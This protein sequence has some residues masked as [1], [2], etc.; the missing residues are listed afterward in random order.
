VRSTL[1][2]TLVLAVTPAHADPADRVDSAAPDDLVNRPLVLGEG[3]L[4][5]R[6]TAEINLQPRFVARPLSF[7][8]DAWWGISPRWTIGLVHSNASLD[9][10]EAGATLCVRESPIS[11]CNRLYRGS[12]L[13]VRF[14]ARAGA[15][16]IAPRVRVLVRD[17][18]P[19][20]PAI[21]LGALVRWSHGRFAIAG[22]PY[23]RLPL[24]NH[25]LGNRAALVVPLWLAVQ[26]ARGWELAVHTGY[27]ADLVVLR[28][29]GHI[30]LGLA[31][32]ARATRELDVRVLAGWSRLLGP[33]HDAQRAALMITA[34]WHRER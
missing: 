12:G 32:T 31:V 25:S 18:D 23:L 9:R 34:G 24:A 33:Q 14:S 22:D 15:L 8:P 3:G 7:A 1:V 2:V 30:P 16:S 19:F 29:D 27:D 10:I 13:D 26:P 20:K 17:L 4:D 28:D 6:L 21:T 5:F 11:T